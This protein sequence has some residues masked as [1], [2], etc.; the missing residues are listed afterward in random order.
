M[1]FLGAALI[2]T[3]L[4]ALPLLVG[5]CWCGNDQLARHSGPGICQ[6]SNDPT[7]LLPPEP[8]HHTP[9]NAA[10]PGVS[11]CHPQ[12]LWYIS[13]PCSPDP[14]ASLPY[15]SKGGS[16]HSMNCLRRLVERVCLLSWSSI[17]NFPPGSKTRSRK[18]AIGVVAFHVTVKNGNAS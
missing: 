8:H 2:P 7:L 3:N 1:R 11:A 18:H 10:R 6:G 5:V 16:P 12:L 13:L 4:S 17:W 15:K 14:V 9:R